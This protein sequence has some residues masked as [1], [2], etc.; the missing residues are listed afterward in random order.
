[1]GFNHLTYLLQ[2]KDDALNEDYI[3]PSSIG[4]LIEGHQGL[5]TSLGALRK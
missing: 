1:M 2:I 5:Y 4:K 3:L